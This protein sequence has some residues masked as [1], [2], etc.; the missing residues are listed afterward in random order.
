MKDQ[1]RIG[2]SGHHEEDPI[3]AL[4]SQELPTPSGSSTRLIT[5]S[6]KQQLV[7]NVISFRVDSAEVNPEAQW[8]KRLF[9]R[10]DEVVTALLPTTESIEARLAVFNYLKGIVRHALG[11]EIFP[12]GSFVGRVFLLEGDIDM[13][14]VLP[15]SLSPNSWFVKLNETLCMA[16]MGMA[17]KGVER[18]SF[19]RM[20]VQNVSFINAEVKIIKA[21][22]NNI[23]VDI[24]AN[25]ISAL[26]AQPFL[27]KVNVL[28]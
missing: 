14:V 10:F 19:L 8:V 6:E 22:I 21:S 15:R 24:S 11:V 7:A 28:C 16:A 25:Q 2:A 18:Q 1:Y 9:G 27:E 20:T 3:S 13:T 23:S 17:G 5:D 4:G 12:V 26:Y